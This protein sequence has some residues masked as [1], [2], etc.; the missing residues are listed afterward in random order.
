MTFVIKKLKIAN[1]AEFKRFR[2][3]AL[4][5]SPQCF[6]SNYDA[7]CN[8]DDARF[9]RMMRD[10]ECSFVMAAFEGDNIVSMLGFGSSESRHIIHKAF[11]WGVYTG[12]NH[13]GKSLAKKVMLAAFEAVKLRPQIKILQLGTAVDN[14]AAIGLYKSFGFISYGIEINALIINGKSIDENL[15]YLEI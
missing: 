10:D 1:L 13:R 14:H 8:Y 5:E 3:E 9:L 2:L 7:E 6:G 4:F 11:I 12:V 15:M